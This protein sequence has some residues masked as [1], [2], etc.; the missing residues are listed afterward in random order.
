MVNDQPSRT[1]DQSVSRRRFVKAVG[2]T[3]AVAGLAGCTGGDGGETTTESTTTGSGSDTTTGGDGTSGKTTVKWASD[4]RLKENADAIKQALHDAG[5]SKDIEVEIIAGAWETGKRQQQYQ[6]W[7]SE[8]RAEPDILMMDN[9]WTIPFIA[10]GQ[11]L[12]LSEALPSDLVKT[13]ENDY[14]QAS[15]QTVK[16]KNGDLFGVPFFPDFP[17]MQYRKDLVE[18]AG[19]GPE[20]QSWATE[21]MTWKKFAEV[22][23]AVH[24]QSDAKY[25]FTFQ[26]KAYEG[27]SCC[28]F[29]EFM[30]SW[31]GAY[32]GAHDNLFGPVGDRPVT[33]DEQPVIDAIKMVRTFIHGQDDAHALDGWKGGFAPS[34][35]LQWTEETSRKPFTNGD[36]VMHRNW[37]Y[38]I[39]INGKEEN[40][41]KDLGVMPIPYG[42]KEADAKY[43]NTGGPVAA[44][45]GWHHTV[46]P[47][48]ARKEASLEVLKAMMTEEFQL[49]VLETIGWLPPKPELFNSSRAKEIPVMGRYMDTLKVAGENAIPRPVTVVWPTESTKIA[50]QVNAAL[51][52][53]KAPEKAMSDLKN[54]LTAIE[55]SA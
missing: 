55:N 53:Q 2:A 34:T 5:L 52:Q 27:L 3:G 11:L 54:Q 19:Y 31:G 30:S 14:F 23:K 41:G 46:N 8:K 47:N 16:G 20:G 45:G 50:Q 10:R 13:V 1:D 29:N 12:N 15:V 39:N 36:A 22:T 18:D 51:G 25:G 32:F 43:K 42:V 37:P 44:L 33:V 40:F 48:T 26:A 24:G 38:S 17:T 28:D 9:G 49:A 7:L 21:S 35:V 6:L 4:P